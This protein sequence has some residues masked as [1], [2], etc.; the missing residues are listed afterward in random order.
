MLRAIEHCSRYRLRAHRRW[1]LGALLCLLVSVVMSNADAQRD[2]APAFEVASV[3]L[4]APGTVFSQRLTDTRLDLGKF[5]LR[6]VLWLAFR[7]DSLP[8]ERLS[9]PAWAQDLRVDIHATFP[10]GRRALV[11]EML[12]RLLAERFGLRVSV[13]PRLTDVYELVVGKDG[14]RMLEV[15]AVNELDKKFETN[16]ALSSAVRDQSFEDL[17]GPVRVTMTPRGMRTT[18]E[19]STYERVFNLGRPTYQL[20]AARISMEEFASLLTTNVARP[21]FDSTKLTG[22]YQFKIELPLDAA[23]VG[24]MAPLGIART[25]GGQPL[26]DPTG[27]SAVKAV[28]QLGLSLEPRRI[29]MD[30]IVV[31]SLSKAPTEN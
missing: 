9:A 24:V 17:A 6:Q 14:I 27:V 1:A 2:Q 3:R 31:D 29:P 28:E 10:E 25:A 18:T 20:D 7:I 26:D 16:T 30:T 5:P 12:Q 8:T 4:S 11:P 21:V 15:Q 22:L 19:R 13:T 23:Y